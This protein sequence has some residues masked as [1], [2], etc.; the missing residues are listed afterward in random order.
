MTT[1][2][3]FVDEEATHVKATRGSTGRATSYPTRSL[4]SGFGRR[5]GYA[6]GH[7][8]ALES[9]HAEPE[10]SLDRGAFDPAPSDHLLA[11]PAPAQAGRK[12]MPP[13]GK[14]RPNVPSG[15]RHGRPQAASVRDTAREYTERIS[16]CRTRRPGPDEDGYTGCFNCQS[17]SHFKR[18]CKQPISDRLADIAK[19]PNDVDMEEAEMFLHIRS[20]THGDG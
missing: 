4:P 7:L 10:Q 18:E 9:D 8:S 1:V 14:L 17:Q 15:A 2:Q 5:P 11:L 20:A 16:S 13:V 3:H 6:G 19:D 12:G